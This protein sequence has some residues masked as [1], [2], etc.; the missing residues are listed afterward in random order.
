MTA[1]YPRMGAFI[2][3]IGTVAFETVDETIFFDQD[4]ET[5]L[6]DRPSTGKGRDLPDFAGVTE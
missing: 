2:R 5:G 4:E 6:S 1:T 3:E